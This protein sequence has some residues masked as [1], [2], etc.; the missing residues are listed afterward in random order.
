MRSGVQEEQPI[1]R[2]PPRRPSRVEWGRPHATNVHPVEEIGATEIGASSILLP[3]AENTNGV[4]S[5]D[6]L[7]RDVVKQAARRSRIGWV[8][9]VDEEEAQPHLGVAQNVLI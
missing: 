8:E 5:P 7:G 3:R 1:V 4:T 6:E 2:Q 9:L